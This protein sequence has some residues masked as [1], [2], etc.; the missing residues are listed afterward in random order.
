[1]T[2][3]KTASTFVFGAVFE[4]QR[5]PSDE[6]FSSDREFFER[7][8][9]AS[10]TAWRT[11]HRVTDVMWVSSEPNHYGKPTGVVFNPTTETFDTVLVTSS[12]HISDPVLPD[13]YKEFAAKYLA[14]VSYTDEEEAPH[15]KGQGKSDGS[16]ESDAG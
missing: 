2:D 11:K 7:F 15:V 16:D 4:K 1:M 14:S 10:F 8:P 3:R 13:D 12:V 6:Q 9:R 5:L